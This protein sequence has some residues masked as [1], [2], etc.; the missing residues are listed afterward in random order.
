MKVGGSGG[1]YFYGPFV[2]TQIFG[3]FQMTPGA[4]P[5]QFGPWNHI[6]APILTGRGRWLEMLI[7]PSNYGDRYFVEIGLGALGNEVLWQ[8]S[9]G[10]GFEIHWDDPIKWPVPFR[11]SFPSSVGT[12]KEFCTRCSTLA[13]GGLDIFATIW[14][15]N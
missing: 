2:S 3:T 6:G 4:L 7:W 15:W 1:G 8:P 13:G 10:F 5:L 12:G 9:G 14:L 11:L